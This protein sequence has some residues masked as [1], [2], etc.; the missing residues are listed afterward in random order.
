RRCSGPYEGRGP[1]ERLAEVAFVAALAGGSL[2]LGLGSP[3]E[4]A[5]GALAVLIG[6]PLRDF[7]MTKLVQLK[8]YALTPV[9]DLINH[10]SGVD[11]DVSYNYFYGYFAVTTKNGWEAG[12]QVFISYGPRSNDHLLQRYG[13]VEPSNP[14]DVY[15]I[16]GLLDKLSGLVGKENVKVLRESGASLGTEPAE[17]ATVG[18]VGLVDEKEEAR[19]MPALRL[20]VVK[21]DQV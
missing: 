11:S 18:R 20:A 13:F 1:K 10:K 6:I 9:V 12:E 15:R 19:V 17:S 16:T 3:D 7:F 14:N 21:D 5:N 4:V 8:R 2:G